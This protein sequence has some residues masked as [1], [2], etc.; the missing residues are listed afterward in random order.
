MRIEEVSS[1]T[2][3]NEGLVL[4]KIGLDPSKIGFIQEIMR[5]KI[6]TYP[7]L[8]CVRE[9]LT[10]ALD[11]SK[12]VGKDASTITVHLP[13]K[14]EP[15]FSVK[16]E[17]IG[18]SKEV[19]LKY[20]AEY[21]NSLAS[22]SNEFT[23]CYG[24]GSKAPFTITNSFKVL[25]SWEGERYS[26]VCFITNEGNNAVV[27]S[28]QLK[29]STIGTEIVIEDIDKYITDIVSSYYNLVY[30][31][32]VK[33]K[34]NIEVLP[35]EVLL[36]GD[37]WE[38]INNNDITCS[39][40]LKSIINADS[41][42][43]SL[44]C[45][46][47]LFTKDVI[48][49]MGGVSYSF[50]REDRVKL[51]QKI[52]DPEQPDIKSFIDI[53][54][55]GSTGY[56]AYGSNYKKTIVFNCDIGSISI[57]P[58]REYIDVDKSLDFI[59]SKF[60]LMMKE[61]QE[62]YNKK[63]NS[64]K[65]IIEASIVNSSLGPLSLN[66]ATFK[67]VVIPKNNYLTLNFKTYRT[68]IEKGK[69]IRRYES[70]IKID[71]D[72]NIIV[73][74]VNSTGSPIPNIRNILI[75]NY[76]YKCFIVNTGTMSKEN[77][78]EAEKFLDPELYP[79]GRI[80]FLSDLVKPKKKKEPSAK[81][82]VST[83]IDKKEYDSLKSTDFK[84]SLKSLKEPKVYFPV[85]TWRSIYKE[86]CVEDIKAIQKVFNTTI[87][88][89]SDADLDAVRNAGWSYWK[90]EY[91]DLIEENKS[92]MQLAFKQIVNY[93]KS[94]C[95]NNNV[96]DFNYDYFKRAV[97][98]SNNL[99]GD[100]EVKRDWAIIKAIASKDKSLASSKDYTSINGFINLLEEIRS[101]FRSNPISLFPNIHMLDISFGI[102]SEVLNLESIVKD[103]IRAR[104]IFSN[105]NDEERQFLLNTL[106]EGEQ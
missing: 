102:N 65:D 70:N 54:T 93:C 37:G 78:I 1:K 20:F 52:E 103:N 8:A 28:S 75:E 18:M 106:F 69:R 30:L 71:K 91:K 55:G 10:N 44:N 96:S 60:D 7:V 67:G 16:D 73:D 49:L 84:D 101:E 58:Q 29:S 42:Y 48:F 63:I 68:G 47:K 56:Y 13:T 77:I 74:N 38:V 40:K 5:S 104:I 6:Y 39:D 79:A 82:R 83:L 24:L 92:K 51:S 9:V 34:C 66:R 15:Y 17:G 61:V 86:L 22:G 2:T 100:N 57:S 32:D 81:V 62:V 72:L 3:I 50:R 87:V 89:I 31:W 27:L 85:S 11:A 64:C 94:N 25:T 26:Y 99:I 14:S 21:G 97:I 35:R 76:F 36:S 19:F 43:S 12:K 41:N 45:T 98:F 53:I 33:P 59:R 88:G 4:H 105:K 80:L 46:A 95:L 90:D 23:G